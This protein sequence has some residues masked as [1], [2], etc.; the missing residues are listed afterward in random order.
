[1]TKRQFIKSTKG[2]IFSATFIK[3]DG[4]VRR[5]NARL[6]V[7]KGVKGTGMKYDPVKKGLITVFD[8]KKN[9]H[10]MINLKTLQEFHC[11]K[12]HWRK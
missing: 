8:L 9:A 3:K 5:M 2:K 7:S 11:G 4:S 1:M 6:G 12:Q 10:R